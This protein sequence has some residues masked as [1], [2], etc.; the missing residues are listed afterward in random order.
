MA[1]RG[2]KSKAGAVVGGGD[3]GADAVGGVNPRCRA[4]ATAIVSTPGTP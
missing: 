2:E 4:S 1:F 3:V